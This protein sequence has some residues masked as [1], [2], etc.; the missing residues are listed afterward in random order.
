MTLRNAVLISAVST[1][2]VIAGFTHVSAQPGTPPNGADGQQ[3]ANEAVS[4]RSNLGYAAW[5][6]AVDEDEARVRQ[7]L[8]AKISVEFKETP[9]REALDEVAKQSGVSI[10]I[11][12]ERLT[13]DG[14]VEDDFELPVTLTG[15]DTCVADV[16]STLLEQ[17][18]LSFMI[19][20]YYQREAIVVAPRGCDESLRTVLYDVK[21]LL[22]LGYRLRTASPHEI[23]PDYSSWF[24]LPGTFRGGLLGIG[25]PTDPWVPAKTG[26]PAYQRIIGLYNHWPSLNG[27]K[28]QP[29]DVVGAMK[30][31]EA[32]P[33][34]QDLIVEHTEGPWV[35]IDGVGGQIEVVGTTL[36]IRQTESVHRE[37]VRLF[38][39]L[40]RITA[41]APV[42][43]P[44][45]IDRVLEDPVLA[46]LAKRVTVDFSE[47][48]IIDA[49]HDLWQQTGAQVEIAAPREA[50]DIV[51][52]AR[53]ETVTLNRANAP[54]GEVLTQIAEEKSWHLQVEFGR[55]RLDPRTRVD[56]Q[57]GAAIYDLRD[58]PAA[59]RWLVIDTLLN[60]TDGP[61]IDIDAVGG[62][63]QLLENGLLIVRQT[64][65]NHGAVAVWLDKLRKQGLQHGPAAAETDDDE[66]S[67]RIY[68][69]ENADA[70][71][72]L[73]EAVETFVR[74]ETWD[75]AGGKGA[76]RGAGHSLI[77]RQNGAGH[78]DVAQLLLRIEQAHRYVSENTPPPP[79][80]QDAAQ[81]AAPADAAQPAARPVPSL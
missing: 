13:N 18:E 6:R 53:L 26:F 76:I 80:T 61:W 73:V 52:A 50:A 2:I 74:P 32:Y 44:A 27:P 37:V 58:F 45:A 48:P 81:D 79:T 31:H 60:Q 47:T 29:G 68:P 16:L 17:S 41:A 54:L 15:A 40:Q 62:T 49:L 36:L 63:A 8:D 77:I 43:E 1:G 38:E 39:A 75:Q 11:D 56:E 7:A 28:V 42:A 71:P 34:L 23:S 20:Y 9:L 55:L 12:W 57:L 19:D 35:D 22:N 70:V 67:T 33:S 66:W 59:N 21:P 46:A 14:V 69:V 25:A 51:E 4:G 64:L 10:R 72:W 78:R 30:L 3:D 5:Y 65:A 24:P